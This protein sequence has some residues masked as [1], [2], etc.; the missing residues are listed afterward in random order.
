M[1]V[2]GKT[3][4][5]FICLT[6]P[7]FLAAPAPTV[8]AAPVKPVSFRFGTLPVIQALPL[9]VA[10]EK[11]FFA[12]ERIDIT[13]DTFPSAM[14]KDMALSTGEI[15]GYFGDM[16]TPITLRANG[17]PVRIVATNFT[18]PHEQRMF[19]LVAAPEYTE[20]TLKTL[21][22]EGVAGSPHTLLDYL[23]AKMLAAAEYDGKITLIDVVKIP[24]RLQMV[25]TSQVPAALLPEPLVTFAVT[26]GCR[27]VADDASLGVSATILAFTDDFIVAS[28]GTV[29]AFLAAVNRASLFIN[30][31][32][33]ESRRI[34]NRTCRIPAPLADSFPLPAFPEISRPR[35]ELVMDVYRWL[36]EKGYIT[37]ELSYDDIVSHE[38]AF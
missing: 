22:Q 37:K 32:P 16:L 5:L 15:A 9:F 10:D 27:V 33:D 18:T 1:T 20:E 28:P 38:P 31:V 6:L 36:T 3:V 12:E 19:A 13:L 30:T 21:I 8:D 14:E 34:M 11:G 26:K 17:V 25:L 29:R 24:L 2:N 4:I 35:E 23:M 7:C